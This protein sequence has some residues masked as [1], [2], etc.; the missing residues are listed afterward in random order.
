M[1]VLPIW[2]GQRKQGV[3]YGPAIM[4][5]IAQEVSDG[6]SNLVT[7]HFK[8]NVI[9]NVDGRGSE[10][11]YTSHMN[12]LSREISSSLTELKPGDTVLNL[13]GDHSVAMAT[14]QTMYNLYPDLR[15]VWID[16]HA[17]INSPETSP[18]GRVENFRIFVVGWKSE[19]WLTPF[20]QGI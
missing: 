9:N 7:N 19:L 1:N 20:N 12:E 18:S 2:T 13:G 8:D 5:S 6:N 10:E 4:S 16:A 3:R 14:V 17:D 15:V 11:A